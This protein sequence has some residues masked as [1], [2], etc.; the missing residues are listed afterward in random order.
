MSRRTVALLV[1]LPVA[2]IGLIS[3]ATFAYV[4][5]VNGK[6]PA[7]LTVDS[8]GTTTTIAPTG[9]E[10]TTAATTGIDGTWKVTSGSRAGYRVKE[11][12]FGQSA[13][14][15]GRTSSI[16]GTIVISG[17][18]VTSGSFTADLTAVASNES[19]RDD[20]FQ[21]RIMDTSRFPNATFELTAPIALGSVPAEGATVSA[22]ATGKLTM[23]G[24]TKSVTFTVSAKRSASTIAVA[25]SIPISFADFGIDNPSGGPA[26][27]GD[28]G[29]LEFALNL[30]R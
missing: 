8:V 17:T 4:H 29:I 19:R 6:Q 27:V 20:Q 21:G 12:L 30:G 22:K 24:E 5:F 13:D 2:L 3:A 10:V 9:S 15:V 7:A 16:T 11:V 25:G 23:H 28:S 18:S 14:A 1:G 26:S